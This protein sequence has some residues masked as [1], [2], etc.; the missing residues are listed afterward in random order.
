MSATAELLHIPERPAS[1]FIPLFEKSPLAILLCDD[2]GNIVSINPA[3]EEILE[4][5]RKIGNSRL[6]FSDFVQAQ[7]RLQAERLMR[8][9]A[10]G[11]QQTFQLDTKVPSSERPVR[12]TAWKV[13]GANRHSAG[14]FAV[15]EAVTPLSA[16]QE[17]LRQAQRLEVLGR[18]SGGVAHDVNNLLTGVLL[19][20][21]LLLTTL[22]PGQS[23]RQYAEEIRKAGC[24]AA[25]LVKQMLT[26]ARP[27]SSSPRLL[28]L[29]EIAEG[30]KN[31]LVRLVGE[32][33]ELRFH[34]DPNLGLVRMDI[35]QLQQI[36][37]NLVLNARDALPHGGQV[38][39]ETGN[40]K[41][42]ILPDAATG[43]RAVPTLSCALFVVSD[44]GYGMDEATRARLFEPFF[45]TK[46][47][48]GTGLGLTTVQEIVTSSGGLIYVD[49]QPMKGTRVSVLLPLALQE[50]SDLQSNRKP[51]FD[52]SEEQFPFQ[53]KE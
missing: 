17:R 27:A 48:R 37:L 22:E 28:S 23:A 20:C 15:G 32:S 8:A 7:D 41:I 40:R 14:V 18:L 9:V 47:S 35:T 46:G 50:S 21:D 10:D 53:T 34:L 16:G 12:W 4:T 36:L 42:Q 19:Y 33:I 11:D 49:S 26:F 51:S 5:W 2:D 1:E 43:H 44:N 29:N 45:T 13:D 24:Q 38:R 25:S 39:V 31:L 6:R 3:C 30:M 52:S